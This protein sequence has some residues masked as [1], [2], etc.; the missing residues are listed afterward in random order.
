M[1]SIKA[2]GLADF[3]FFTFLKAKRLKN[4]RMSKENKMPCTRHVDQ[5]SHN[6]GSR[7]LL[8]CR[9]MPQWKNAKFFGGKT[10]WMEFRGLCRR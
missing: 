7:T 2:S 1:G 5:Q 3:V 6:Q 9:N 4:K 10:I 8:P